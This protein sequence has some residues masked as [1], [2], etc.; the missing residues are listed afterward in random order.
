LAVFVLP[1]L[2]V[3]F[4]YVARRQIRETG[5]RGIELAQAAI[6]AGWILTGLMGIGLLFMC[7]FGILWFATFVGILG[8]ASHWAP[9]H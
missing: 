1:P 7:G 9:Y 2:G 4:G 5:E 8:T 3:Y 6:V